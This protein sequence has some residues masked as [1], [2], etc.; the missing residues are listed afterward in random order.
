MTTYDV[1]FGTE[2]DNLILIAEGTESASLSA[3]YLIAA[4]GNGAYDTTY[5]WRVDAV[6]EF[7]VTQ[8]DT[9][10]FTTITFDPPLPLGLSLDSGS[11]NEGT[12]VTGTATGENNIITIKRLVAAA[13]NTIWYEDI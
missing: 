10:S 11:G 7:G 12:G 5:Y 1:Y 9:W 3:A 13:A 8:G 4:Y 6:N 2:P